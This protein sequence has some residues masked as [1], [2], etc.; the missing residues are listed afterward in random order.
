MGHWQGTL[1][2]LPASMPSPPFCWKRGW[3]IPTVRL[4]RLEPMAPGRSWPT[5]PFIETNATYFAGS[6]TSAFSRNPRGLRTISR[7]PIRRSLGSRQQSRDSRRNRLADFD[8][9]GW[10]SATVVDRSDYHL[11]A[12]MA[13][14]ERE[15]AELKPVS[16]TSTNGAWLVDFGRC[17]D[18][19]PKLTM[20]ANQ[21]GRR[22][23]R[24]ILSNDGRTKAR[25]LGRI[26]LPRRHGN[27]E[28]GLRTPY[29]VPGA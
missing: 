5:P 23:A 16:V 29:F 18:G 1:E 12:Q 11:F 9:S 22:R 27:L 13:P 21:S 28:R 4:P 10:A 2:Q 24:G 17:I 20:R 3:T 7:F 19:W 8:D 25:R 6:R 26:Y 14:L 15:Q